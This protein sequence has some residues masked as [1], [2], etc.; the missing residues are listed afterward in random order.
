[1]LKTV[2]LRFG[3]DE[4][5]PGLSFEPGPMTVFV[6]PN[7]SGKSLALRELESFIESGGEEQG[8]IVEGVEPDLPAPGVVRQMVLSRQVTD[9][10]GPPPA[11]LTRVV[12]LKS[13]GEFSRRRAEDPA[14]PLAEQLIDL[15]AVTRALRDVDHLADEEFALLCRDV[16]TLFLIR[17][18]GQTRL[19]LTQPRAAGRPEDHP[20]HHLAA[21][22]RDDAARERIR[23]I[24][25]DAFNLYF[26]IDNSTDGELFRI[27]MSERPPMDDAEEQGD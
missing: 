12:R 17:L 24:T 4:D 6:G 10:A 19:A 9:G 26:V 18:D 3:A 14:E 11:G 7:N 25:G 15:D 1:M 5:E 21:L 13:P 20:A 16:L 27:R 8:F 2:N 23:E 22:W